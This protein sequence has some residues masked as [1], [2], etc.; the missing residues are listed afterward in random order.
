MAKTG[1]PAL[2]RGTAAADEF[3]ALCRLG[4]SDTKIAA[5][6]DLSW[7]TA[8]KYRSLLAPETARRKKMPPAGDTAQGAF[9]VGTDTQEGTPDAEGI[10]TKE[11]A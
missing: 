6:F 4:W 8:R 2:E 7:M 3:A 10:G 5:H 11:V 1:I 9:S